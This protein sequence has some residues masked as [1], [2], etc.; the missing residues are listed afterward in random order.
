VL[1]PATDV[2][3]ASDSELQL[4]VLLGP[5]KEAGRASESAT[6]MVAARATDS[7]Q[8][9]AV[10][11]DA[12]KVTMSVCP[13][14]LGSDKAKVLDSAPMTGRPMVRSKGSTTAN[15]KVPK[16]EEATAASMASLLEVV[17]AHSTA[18]PTAA[19]TECLSELATALSSGSVTASAMD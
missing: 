2:T 19:A 6:A 15:S 18:T 12:L 9:M 17:S 4:E 7:E 14:G 10:S 16:K 8:S 1:E 13:K 5:E 11:S 3:T